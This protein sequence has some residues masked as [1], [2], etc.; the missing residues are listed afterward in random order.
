MGSDGPGLGHAP[1]D[2]VTMAHVVWNFS[3]VGHSYIPTS[4]VQTGRS[5]LNIN[6]LFCSL[7]KQDC[8]HREGLRKRIH[9]SGHNLYISSSSTVS[10]M[11][12]V[13][14]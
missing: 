1:S 8:S 9:M 6:Y 10:Q 14:W 2:P 11:V 7:S 5:H 4:E 12:S 3:L 13:R